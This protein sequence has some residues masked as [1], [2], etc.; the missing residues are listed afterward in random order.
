M[1]IA[2]VGRR[3]RTG[4]YEAWLHTM[5]TVCAMPAVPIITLN[6]GE[7]TSCNGLLLP[8]GGDITPSFFNEENQGSQ[9]IDTEL[10]ILQLQALDYAIRHKIPVLG[11]CKGMQ[12]INVAFGGTLVQDLPAGDCHRFC[13]KDRYH[14]TII[15]ENS[16]LYPLYG[17]SAFV[18][19]AH[20]QAV[21]QVGTG[22][23]PIQWCDTDGCIEALQHNVLP[24]LGVQWH[25]ER[26]DKTQ[27]TLSGAPLLKLFSSLIQNACCASASA[28]DAP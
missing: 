6:P 21:G 19:S 24:I 11:V 27:T 25:P 4:N 20:H 17:K 18:N 10:D 16:C 8:G 14:S 3:A 1:K 26:L 28:S 7:L 22:L 23:S 2:I 9:N 12:L 15:S 5:R 13:G